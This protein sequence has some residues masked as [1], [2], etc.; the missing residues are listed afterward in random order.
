MAIVLAAI[1][2]VDLV[3]AVVVDAVAADVAAVVDAV[4]HVAADAV[5]I[6]ADGNTSTSYKHE[7]HGDEPWLF[8]LSVKPP[9]ILIAL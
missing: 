8:C 7:S 3:R 6:A 1:V 9:R 2:I 4:V 5:E